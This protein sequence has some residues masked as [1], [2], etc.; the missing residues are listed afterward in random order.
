M[1]DV[2]GADV[3]KLYLE[4]PNSEQEPAGYALCSE[5]GSTCK[6]N[7]CSCRKTCKGKVNGSTKY[8]SVCVMVPKGKECI[9]SGEHHVTCAVGGT[10]SYSTTSTPKNNLNDNNKNKLNDSS[11]NEPNTSNKNQLNTSSK[12]QLTTSTNDQLNNITKSST[13]DSAT[14]GQRQH[15]G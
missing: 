7:G 14:D 13:T 12:N 6:K 10:S 8:F 4:D 9:T 5:K 3:Q 1:G 2:C 11:K 15:Y